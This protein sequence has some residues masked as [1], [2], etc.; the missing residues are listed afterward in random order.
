MPDW[1]KMEE[2]G[3]RMKPVRDVFGPVKNRA[4]PVFEDCLNYPIG[5]VVAL[6]K[7]SREIEGMAFAGEPDMDIVKA[8]VEQ[9]RQMLEAIKPIPN[10]KPRIYLWPEGKMPAMT[11]YT[12]NSDYRYN[13]NPDFRPY[14]FELLVPED[15]EPKG[16]VVL[17]A[18]GDH[19]DAVVPEAYQSA[20]DLNGLGYQCFLLLNRTNHNPWTAQEAGVDA[21]RAVRMVRKDAAKYRVS[22]NNI[23]FAGFSNGGISA[24]G[25]LENYSGKKIVKDVFPEYMPDELDEIDA[26]PDAYLCVYGPRFAGD[27]FN[28]DGVVYPPTFFAVGREDTAMDNLNATYPDLIAHGVQVE[29]HTFA[30]VP[31]GQA[32]AKIMDGEVK[33]PNF[34]MWLPLADAFMQDVYG[35]AE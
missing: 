12:D 8:K 20:L 18:G 25:L 6:A 7:L 24:E 32:G 2:I 15:V 31:H 4:V 9:F 22:S 19:G 10:A 16:A 1:S 27:T 29:V 14:L 23:A 17:C 30:G 21:A 13:H 3:K 35:K 33:Y 26:T 28:Y 5:E 11:D 34:E